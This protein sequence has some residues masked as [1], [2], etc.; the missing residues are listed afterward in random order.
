MAQL[1]G[2]SVVEGREP[3]DPARVSLDRALGLLLES[4]VLDETPPQLPAWRRSGK[5]C[6]VADGVWIRPASGGRCGGGY[7]CG[8]E[9]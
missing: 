6:D 5:G 1:I 3:V 7:R 2:G 8:Y 9:R 4:E